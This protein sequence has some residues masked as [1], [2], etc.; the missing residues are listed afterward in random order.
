LQAVRQRL[1]ENHRL[2]LDQPRHIASTLSVIM[3]HTAGYLSS[4][5]ILATSVAM[6]KGPFTIDDEIT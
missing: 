1:L 6:M 2:T 3:E 4:G 5:N